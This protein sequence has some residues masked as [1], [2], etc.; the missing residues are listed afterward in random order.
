MRKKKK[1]ENY[2]TKINKKDPFNWWNKFWIVLTIF[3]VILEFI[4][5]I[6]FRQTI[7]PKSIMILSFGI[8]FILTAFQYRQLRKTKVFIVWLL[9]CMSLFGLFLYLKYNSILFTNEDLYQIRG[10]KAPTYFLIAFYLFRKISTSIWNTELIMP[11]RGNRYDT[12]EGRKTN[13]MDYIA[14]F[15]YWLIIVFT[16]FYS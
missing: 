9:I 6:F 3:I 7:Q 16:Y 4:G 10:L 11:S 13:L 5:L 15:S 2:V 14:F 8:P 12:E 1:K